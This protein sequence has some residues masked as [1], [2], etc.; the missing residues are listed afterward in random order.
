MNSNNNPAS[1]VKKR[2]AQ[3]TISTT[4]LDSHLAMAIDHLNYECQYGKAMA[5]DAIEARIAPFAVPKDTPGWESLA[6][7]SANLL[8]AWARSIREYAN[9][10]PSA[11]SSF[12][13]N[14]S[15][16]PDYDCKDSQARDNFYDLDNDEGYQEDDDEVANNRTHSNDLIESQLKQI[17]LLDE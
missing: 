3:I 7:R 17:G 12:D 14:H 11:T 8:E 10:P 15:I 13:Q 1:K 5:A 16:L 2:A 9:L 6:I 4:F